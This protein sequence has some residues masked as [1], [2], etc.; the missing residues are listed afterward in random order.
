MGSVASK[1][2][3]WQR[4]HAPWT[5]VLAFALALAAAVLLLATTSHFATSRVRE[6]GGVSLGSAGPTGIAAVQAADTGPLRLV[7]PGLVA[8]G[9]FLEAH[10][11]TGSVFQG[12]ATMVAVPEGTSGTAYLFGRAYPLELSPDGGSV[13]GLVGVGV[14]DPVGETMLTVEATDRAGSA[15]TLERPITILQ[16]PWTV[17]YIVL[18]PGVGSGLT[19]DIVRDEE[20]LLASTYADLSPRQW[21]APFVS[22]LDEPRITG[23]FGEQRSFNGGTPTGHHGGTDFGAFEGTPVY[24]MNR[25]TVVIARELAVRGNMVIVDHG[26]G[27]FSGYAHLSRVD[28]V[29]GQA[30]ETG[31]V[32]G[33]VGTTGLSTGNHLHWEVALRGILVDGLRWIDGSQGY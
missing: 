19:P 20:E 23:Y 9:R 6:S 25:G 21:L 14:L 31:Q 13:E 18:P 3:P 24:A 16:T 4:R 7:L 8:Q 15:T 12:G 1:R 27:V 32:L 2:N 22:P 30:V 5:P 29:E 28:V 10:V 33:G 11:S 17:D 26:G